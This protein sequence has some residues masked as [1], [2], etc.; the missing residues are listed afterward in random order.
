MKNEIKEAVSSQIKNKFKDKSR[1][2]KIADS[3]LFLAD[4]WATIKGSDAL[5]D[6]T[7]SQAKKSCKKYIKKHL[8]EQ[9]VG[10]PLVTILFSVIVKLI[11]EWVIEN[12]IT[13]L[14]KNRGQ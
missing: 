3:C 8:K 10:N 7:K 11:I 2:R 9:I 5:E 14:L 1:N 4:E 13:N 12:Y 6:F